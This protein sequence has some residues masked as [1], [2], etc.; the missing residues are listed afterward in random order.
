MLT[1]IIFRFLPSWRDLWSDC[2]FRTL[3]NKS[4]RINET[5]YIS[6]TRWRCSVLLYVITC[7]RGCRRCR[8]RWSD[9]GWGWSPERGW[10]T[11]TNTQT[12]IRWWR[13]RRWMITSAISWRNTHLSQPRDV[14]AFPVLHSGL[15]RLARPGPFA[16]AVGEAGPGEDVVVGQVQV[17]RVHSK[18]ADQ[19]QQAGQAV[20]QPL[21]WKPQTWRS[22]DTILHLETCRSNY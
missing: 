20:E 8:P 14:Q 7:V 5:C 17:C 21:Q 15:A 3:L 16:L 6:N 13:T 11:P 12:N 4:Q 19:L 22:H 2:A 9:A 10:G 18:L 1:R